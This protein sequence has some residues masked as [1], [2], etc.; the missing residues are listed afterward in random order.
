VPFSNYFQSVSQLMSA[1]AQA[2]CKYTAKTCPFGAICR[3][4]HTPVSKVSKRSRPKASKLTVGA[5]IKQAFTDA[6]ASKEKVFTQ[7]HGVILDSCRANIKPLLKDRAKL[8]DLKKNFDSKYV[9]VDVKGGSSNP[10]D[11]QLKVNEMAIAQIKSLMV[12]EFRGMNVPIRLTFT[13][14]VQ[15]TG[16][17]VNQATIILDPA[18][19]GE[20]SGLSAL[21]EQV[22]TKKV[23]LRYHTRAIQVAPGVS[24]T[25]YG[26]GGFVIDTV[27][28]TAAGSLQDII[29]GSNHATY[30]LF[31]NSGAVTTMAP[32]PSQRTTLIYHPPPLLIANATSV[33]IAGGS[34]VPTTGSASNVDITGYCK[35]YELNNAANSAGIGVMLVY[36][37]CEF[38]MRD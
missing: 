10:Y 33:G 25:P 13:V 12:N 18:Y 9:S 29:D 30:D 15:N 34:W 37:D 7:K 23:T 24:A 21:F 5:H 11:D 8:L 36:C 38:R 16:A 4:K 32:T 35:F 31:H 2:P 6:K 19:S 3:F 27:S 14:G 20:F 28:I 22:R 17:N 26:V 1:A